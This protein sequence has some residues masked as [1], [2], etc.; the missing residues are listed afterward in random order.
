MRF[1]IVIVLAKSSCNTRAYDRNHQS[2]DEVARDTAS[3]RALSYGAGNLVRAED[4]EHM[5]HVQ[6]RERDS[7]HD[8]DGRDDRKTEHRPRLVLLIEIE[9]AISNDTQHSVRVRE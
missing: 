9:G 3:S 8:D 1:E 4:V 7:Q 6:H 2:H 5:K